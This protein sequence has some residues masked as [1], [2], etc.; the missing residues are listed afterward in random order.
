M[1]SQR[2]QVTGRGKTRTQSQLRSA[3]RK[4]NWKKLGIVFG[5]TLLSVAV[6]ETC[7]NFRLTFVMYLY[8]GV[9]VAVLAAFLILNRG[10]SRETLTEADFPSDMDPVKRGALIDRDKRWKAVA[11]KLLYVLAPLLLTLLLDTV[12]LFY[13]DPLLEK[14]RELG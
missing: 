8:Y 4:V 10:F 3:V 6:F 13:I 11:G 7:M 1:K 14:L 12:Y 9:T 2:Y 5:S